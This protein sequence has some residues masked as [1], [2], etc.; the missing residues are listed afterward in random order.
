MIKTRELLKNWR[1]WACRQRTVSALSDSASTISFKIGMLNVLAT[2]FII[3]LMSAW[4]IPPI[5]HKTKNPITAL[6]IHLCSYESNKIDKKY[7]PNFPLPI[8]FISALAQL[9]AEWLP[10]PIRD[11]I[12]M[13]QQRIQHDHSQQQR[14]LWSRKLTLSTL[15]PSNSISSPVIPRHLIEQHKENIFPFLLRCSSSRSSSR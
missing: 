13:Q 12:A 2:Y 9:C 4:V 3:L 1:I 11:F 5:E 6:S 10:P 7:Q 15:A 8:G 14:I